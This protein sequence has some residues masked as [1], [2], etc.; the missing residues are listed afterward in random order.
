MRADLLDRFQRECLPIPDV[1]GRPD[2][3]D[4]A[5]REWADEEEM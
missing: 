4:R 2:Y 1:I 3:F 5:Y